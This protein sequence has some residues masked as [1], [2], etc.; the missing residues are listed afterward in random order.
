MPPPVCCILCS[1]FL[2]QVLLSTKFA[3]TRS[4]RMR[5]SETQVPELLCSCFAGS[6]LS[7]EPQ[8][9]SQHQ[10]ASHLLKM[11]N[12]AACDMLTIECCKGYMYASG[13]IE[14]HPPL[15]C[16]YFASS[17]LSPEAPE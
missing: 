8:S 14:V 2:L 11:L 4:T 16:G 15:L 17:A 6:A 3:G 9:D 5:S 1:T 10:P 7:Q 13:E 12:L